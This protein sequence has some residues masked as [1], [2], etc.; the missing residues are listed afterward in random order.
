MSSHL[1]SDWKYIKAII[2]TMQHEGIGGAAPSR[3]FGSAFDKCKVGRCWGCLFTSTSKSGLLRPF[4][5]N[6]CPPPYLPT[7]AARRTRWILNISARERSI[8]FACKISATRWLIL[9][10]LGVEWCCYSDLLPGI[11]SHDGAWNLETHRSGLFL[12][13]KWKFD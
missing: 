11:C 7:A 9:F 5:L 4:C 6:T 2:I 3:P 13:T 12:I 10:A 8:S 1:Y